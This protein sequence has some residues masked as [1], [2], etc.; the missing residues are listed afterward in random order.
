M[1]EAVVFILDAAP[2]MNAPYPKQDEQVKS[3]EDVK[4]TTR[5]D[6]AKKAIITMISDLMLKSKMNEVSV[7]ICKTIR[8]KHHMIGACEDS[9]EEAENIPFPNLTEL[10][11]GIVRPSVSLLRD[12]SHI[13]TVDEETA[14]DLRGDFCDAIIVAAD[15]LYEKTWK[16]KWERKIVLITD[17]EHDVVM[18]IPQTL[19]VIDSLRSMECRLEVIGLD[20][21]SAAVFDEPISADSAA[22]IKKENAPDDISS[23]SKKIKMEE[24][25]DCSVK[26]ETDYSTL[27]QDDEA[28]NND[29][30]D[31]L[32]K[33]VYTLREDREKL[34]L[35][36]AEKCGGCVI[37]ATKLQHILEASKGKRLVSSQKKKVEFKIAPGVI[38]NARYLLMMKKADEF[39]KLTTKACI[40]DS[41][42]GQPLMDASGEELLEDVL[43]REILVDEDAPD[44]SIDK[45]DVTTA[46]LFGSTLVPMSSFDFEGIKSDRGGPLIEILC[47]LD[48]TKIPDAYL[49]G[50]PYAISGDESQKTCAAISALAQALSRLNRVG[51]CTF[52]KQKGKRPVL[53]ALFPLPEPIYPHPIHLVFLRIPFADEA[54]PFSMDP[55]DGFLKGPQNAVK[56]QSCD[57]LI[58]SL[59]LPNE[60]LNPGQVPYPVSRSW[61]QTKVERAMNPQA[62][63]VSVRGKEDD[64]LSTPAHVLERAL[65]AIQVFRQTF[66]LE[67]KPEKT[68]D[69]AN[70]TMDRKGRKV[71]TYKDYLK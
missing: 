33:V 37:A 10:T 14:N 16:K 43:Q 44:V 18:D 57:D 7:I 28:S 63:V 69:V 56:T 21:A 6:C 31:G 42:S 71:F 27:E 61:N 5:L 2:S 51:I 38:L 70:S 24:D 23:S 26:Q 67:R 11:P 54:K 52:S 53:G 17:A 20:F 46:I 13:Q 1:K 50:P 15:T 32:H 8:T 41:E 4:P 22:K 60:I 62:G 12:I 36:L 40:V 19:Q 49:M 47:Y 66:P 3:E 58:K 48:R 35:S 65:P 25:T 55:L 9:D 39:E 30:D 64:P 45:E 29:E 68:K 59:M 34:L